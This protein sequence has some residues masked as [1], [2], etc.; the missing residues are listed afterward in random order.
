MRPKN[1]PFYLE[2]VN[3]GR[4]S[5]IHIETAMNNSIWMEQRVLVG[6]Y[7]NQ[8]SDN[9]GLPYIDVWKCRDRDQYSVRMVTLDGE[10]YAMDLDQ[11]PRYPDDMFAHKAPWLF[12]NNE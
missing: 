6:R 8:A 12:E 11:M 2:C 5:P 1:D 10:I 9:L 3:N 4:R 7:G